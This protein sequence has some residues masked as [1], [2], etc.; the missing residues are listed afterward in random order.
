VTEGPAGDLLPRQ[1][2]DELRRLGERWRT[3]PLAQ[4]LQYAGRV[5]ALAQDLADRVAAREG[6]AS[7]PVPDLGP[8]VLV[9][10][11]RVLAYDATAAGLAAGLAEELAALRRDLA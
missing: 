5:H 8:G 7:V 9:D 11:L 1:V 10:Q 6:R 3:L 2:Q 4:A